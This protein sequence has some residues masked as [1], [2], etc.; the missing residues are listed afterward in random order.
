MPWANAVAVTHL[1][2]SVIAR[3]W[4]NSELEKEKKNGLYTTGPRSVN[5]Y[6][7]HL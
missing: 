3:D 4:L 2:G 1:A 7:K 5:T 6:A